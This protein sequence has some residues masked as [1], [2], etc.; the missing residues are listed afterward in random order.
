MQAHILYWEYF[1]NSSC[2]AKINIKLSTLNCGVKTKN[3]L[4]YCCPKTTVSCTYLAKRV[5][6]VFM[7][8]V[9][10]IQSKSKW[11]ICGGKR[12]I[13]NCEGDREQILKKNNWC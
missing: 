11:P 6:Y 13:Q 5:V 1:V 2:L 7:T 3:V 8:L 9:S 4:S 10:E 12:G